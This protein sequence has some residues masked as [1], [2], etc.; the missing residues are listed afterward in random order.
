MQITRTIFADKRYYLDEGT[1]LN[2][3]SLLD[4]I[5]R[6]NDM[7]MVLYNVLY[8][9]KYHKTGPL[10]EQT[11]SHWMKKQYQIRDYYIDAVST[12]ASGALSSQRELKR[13][14]LK[15]KE[16]DLQARDEKIRYEQ[17][18][19]EKKQKLKQSLK[20]YLTTGE[21]V[22]PYPNCQVAVHGEVVTL[23]GKK[24]VPAV[25]YERQTE[26]MIRKLKTRIA[27]LTEGRKRA[28]K[29]KQDLL[30]NP[31]RRIVFGTKKRFKEKD[32]PSVS[33]EEWKLSFF[34]SRHASM[35]LPGRHTS[36][37]CN[38]LVSRLE[39]DLIITCMDGKEAVLKGFHLARYQEVWDAMLAAK[40]AERK[41]VCYNFQLRTDRNGRRYLLAS[42]TLNLENRYCNE[43]LEDGCISI[44]LN[45]DHIAMSDVSADGERLESEV[46]PFR[47]EG[48]TNGQITE[49]IGR[50]M[51]KVGRYCMEKKKP[52]IMEDLDTTLSKN[53]MRY[54]SKC[55]NRH[56]SMFAYRK[57]TT[58]LENQSYKQGF[59]I[60]KTDPAY[61]SQMG[62]FLFMKKEGISIHVAASYAIGLKGMGVREKLIPDDRLVEL[63]P[64]KMKEEL[65]NGTDIKSLIPA[66][67]KLTE[68]F[69]GVKT[70]RFYQG[71]P[72]GIFNTKKRKS[73]K[74]L[75]AE[76]KSW[77][78]CNC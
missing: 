56:V 7:K 36:K 70:H 52:L 53:G 42:V 49:E 48:K 17:E 45:Y 55:R 54:G 71:I 40:P 27:L 4:T 2:P 64:K 76:M 78:A 14:Y 19:L 68:T 65:K 23:P 22:V 35:S 28:A 13:L 30:E 24:H 50:L 63:L 41:S 67:K 9:K 62:K 3:A 47:L 11:T 43:S 34:A 33:A 38:Y 12:C 26:T 18:Q 73:L 75:A 8:D 57:M 29:K 1:V 60:L 20:T 32:D 51:S 21:W 77:D 25:Q 74:S 61:T 37:H 10:T 44:D 72:Y 46:L 6:F 58:C 59:G 5:T 15:T 69:R 16:R 66:W 39:N 31:P